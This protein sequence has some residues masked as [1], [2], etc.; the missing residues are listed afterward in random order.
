ML[1]CLAVIPARG[2]SKRLPGKN[3][4]DFLGRPIIV[5]TIDAARACGRFERILVSTEDA[6]IAEVARGA[7]AEVSERPAA[8]AADTAGLV[9]VGIDIL[10]R[11]ERDG[12]SYDVIS[13]LYATAPL[14]HSDDINAVLDLIEP[15]VCDF[16][17]AV[18]RYTHPPHQALCIGKDGRLRPQWPELV[19]RSAAEIGPLCVDNGS[20]YAVTVTA[21]RE[22][23][24][25]YGP[26]LRGWPMP[27]TR[28]VDIDEQNDLDLA[29]RFAETHGS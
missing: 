22:Q 20:T 9:D 6:G 3:T 12:R 15:G 2:G 29:R 27:F 7:G 17:M 1:K 25:F 26:G 14:R 11:E 16:A 28:S 5:W 23:R 4:A 13:F 18:T 21:F 8:L 10:D 19:E 24:T